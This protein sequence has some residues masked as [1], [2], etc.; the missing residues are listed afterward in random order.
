LRLAAVKKLQKKSFRSKAQALPL[1]KVSRVLPGL[2]YRPQLW[3]NFF[4]YLFRSIP[5][6]QL[7]ARILRCAGYCCLL[8][9]LLW[10]GGCFRDDRQ[11]PNG[12]PNL[13]LGNPS[14][15]TADVS[16]HENYLMIKPQY[17]LSYS[18]S[19]GI[20]NW[21]S[22]RLNS[23]DLAE[24]GTSKRQNDFR[25]DPDLPADW[26]ATQP[27]DYTGSGFDRGHLTNSEDRSSNPT[28][29]SAT[30]LMTNIMPQSPD[31]NRGVWVE[32]EKYCRELARNGQELYIIS[33]PQGQGGVGSHGA[34]KKLPRGQVV[35]A[36]TWKVVLVTTKGRG[37]AGIDKNTRAFAVS[38][39]NIQGIEHHP[40]R[41][42]RKTVR[43]IEKI[44]GYNFFAVLP[45]DVQEAIENRE[46][47]D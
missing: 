13:L 44:T 1:H 34:L 28:N 22:W 11:S 14:N 39:P 29:N 2:L 12:N 30:F 10:L 21:V 3:D 43:E 23:E 46:D 15:A 38:I 24:K 33:G 20:P 17:V 42:Y 4:M 41:S 35:P 18:R 45:T 6:P 36:N 32:L 26:P 9:N 37:I 16:N 25:P 47:T 7:L 5:M 40:W 8:V 27:K 19:K 31:N